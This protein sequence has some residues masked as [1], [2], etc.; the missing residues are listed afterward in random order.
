MLF[1]L[2]ATRAA[3]AKVA[4]KS[5]RDLHNQRRIKLLITYAKA[6]NVIRDVFKPTLSRL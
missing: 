2:L 4:L 5:N 6:E 3:C 1:Q